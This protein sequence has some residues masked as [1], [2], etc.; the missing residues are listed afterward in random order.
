M[1]RKQLS[2]IQLEKYM[3][4]YLINRKEQGID[5][6]IIQFE[7]VLLAN[8]MVYIFKNPK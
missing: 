2:L 1:K 4:E 8:F 5:Q 7:H 3:N 6:D